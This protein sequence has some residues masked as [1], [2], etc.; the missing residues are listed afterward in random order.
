MKRCLLILGRGRLST[1]FTRLFDSSVYENLVII[2]S[3]SLSANDLIGEIEYHSPSCI[4][5]LLD[6]SSDKISD[7][8]NLAERNL[9]FRLSIGNILGGRLYFYVRRCVL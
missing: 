5:D 6:P 1:I 9:S 4:I 8:Q 7:F 2:P 3:R